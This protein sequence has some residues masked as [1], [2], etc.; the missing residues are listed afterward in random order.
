MAV[1][2]T[3]FEQARFDLC[4]FETDPFTCG[5]L[6]ALTR[7]EEAVE[8]IP[9][10]FGCHT[11]GMFADGMSQCEAA[12]IFRAWS[13][14]LN[15]WREATRTLQE[16]LTDGQPLSTAGRRYLEY[17]LA[18]WKQAHEEHRTM[19]IEYTLGATGVRRAAGDAGG[20]PRPLAGWS[21]AWA[22]FEGLVMNARRDPGPEG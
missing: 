10:C 22:E 15:N 1:M 19:V 18:G 20:D 6:A 8:G 16:D 13:G 5:E 21:K 7:Y 9:G 17:E 4:E 3:T 11:P 12:G 2:T 14:L